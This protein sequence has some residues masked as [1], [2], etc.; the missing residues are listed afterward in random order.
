MQQSRL[1]S[2]PLTYRRSLFGFQEEL[3]LVEEKA[4]APN[5]SSSVVC[6]VYFW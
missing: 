3:T 4:T 1:D 6:L 5:L 2:A